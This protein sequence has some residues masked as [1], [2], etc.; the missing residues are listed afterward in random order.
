MPITSR[1]YYADLGLERNATPDDIRRAFRRLARDSHPDVN[2][3]D[4]G[5]D[6]KFRRIAEAY[7]VL[8]DPGEK[9]RMT[10]G[11]SSTLEI[12]FQA[13]VGLTISFVRFSE[14]GDSSDRHPD[15]RRVAAISW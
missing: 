7:E 12:S 10:V 6:A 1:D 9:P 2:P 14:T 13:W 4:A 3:G 8:S 5:A 11:M 15:Q